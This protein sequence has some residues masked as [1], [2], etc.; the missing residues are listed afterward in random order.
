MKYISFF[1]E[2]CL[3]FSW[4]VYTHGNKSY[5]FEP[6]K[7]Q[8]QFKMKIENKWVF[9]TKSTYVLQVSEKKVKSTNF[10]CSLS[11]RF[12]SLSNV[13]SLVT[14][15]NWDTRTL[16]YF[17]HHSVWFLYLRHL[18][19]WRSLFTKCYFWSLFVTKSRPSCV[20]ILNF[21]LWTNCQCVCCSTEAICRMP[22]S[23]CSREQV[24]TAAVMI[25]PILLDIK[26]YWSLIS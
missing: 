9:L 25:L 1:N 20:I 8:R 12:F 16:S 21:R 6:W 22:V 15:D 17:P 26:W 18:F 24:M 3:Y 10:H 5:G 7:K 2:I 11:L 14:F 23:F 13:I 19:L 4:V